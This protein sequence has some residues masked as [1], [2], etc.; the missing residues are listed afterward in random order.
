MPKNEYFV[1]NII[2][3]KYTQKSKL[4]SEIVM[5]RWQQQ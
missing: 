5:C 1:Q 4:I 3:V 2:D